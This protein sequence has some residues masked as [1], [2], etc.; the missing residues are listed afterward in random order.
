MKKKLGPKN[1]RKMLLIDIDTDSLRF[2]VIKVPAGDLLPTALSCKQLGALCIANAHQLR[3]KRGGGPLWQTSITFSLS[4]IKWAQ[5]LGARI[6]HT[7][8]AAAEL[9]YVEVV[10]HL[11]SS[12]DLSPSTCMQKAAKCGKIDVLAFL[13]EEDGWPLACSPSGCGDRQPIHIAAIHGQ[14]EVMDWLYRRGVPLTT[15]AERKTPMHFAAAHG[16]VA[17]MEWLKEHGVS[18]SSGSFYSPMHIAAREDKVEAVQWLFD[19]GVSIT[20]VDDQESRQQPMHFA[21]RN[22]AYNVVKWL[23]N[24][25]VSLSVADGDGWRP[26][27]YLPLIQ[28][29]NDHDENVQ[30]VAYEET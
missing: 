5:S 20:A 16:H 2:V 29:L 8:W 9:G 4:R 15:P 23:Y 18:L 13:H 1:Q 12:G 25:G 30:H 24:H 11:R 14:I 3:N 17:V 21:A 27:G 7:G 28:W 10:R 19:H 6:N 22:K 26:N